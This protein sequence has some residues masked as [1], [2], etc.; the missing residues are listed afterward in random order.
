MARPCRPWPPNQSWLFRPSLREW[1]DMGHFWAS[2]LAAYNVGTEN[3]YALGAVVELHQEGSKQ[4]PWKDITGKGWQ[5]SAYT[6]EDPS[7]NISGARFGQKLRGKI[8]KDIRK[9]FQ[10]L[11]VKCNA[12]PVTSETRPILETEA[13]SWSGKSGQSIKRHPDYGDPEPVLG[14][15]HQKLCK[16]EDG[17]KPDWTSSWLQ[18]SPIK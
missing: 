3:A 4:A 5:D 10:N 6:A 16:G 9:D 14:E 2:A 8:V 7:S 11:L 13:K 12:V 15:C 18:T 1:L 17:K